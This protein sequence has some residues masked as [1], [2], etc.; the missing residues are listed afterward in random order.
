MLENLTCWDKKREG[1]KTSLFNK[2]KMLLHEEHVLNLLDI[3]CFLD[4]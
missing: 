3:F 1:L 2:P 4:T